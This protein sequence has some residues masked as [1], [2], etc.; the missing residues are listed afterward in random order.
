MLIARFSAAASVANSGLG[1][2]E[3]DHVDSLAVTVRKWS[4]DYGLPPFA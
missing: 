4:V 1:G 2:I 3:D